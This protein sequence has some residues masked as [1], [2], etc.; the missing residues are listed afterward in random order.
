[1]PD[2]ILLSLFSKYPGGRQRRGGRA[3]S[4]LAAGAA[5]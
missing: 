5:A 2:P 1:M 4:G 3:P